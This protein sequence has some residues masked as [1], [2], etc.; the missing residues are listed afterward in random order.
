MAQQLCATL[1]SAD[2]LSATL[3]LSALSH[4]LLSN[5]EQRTELLR[6]QLGTQQ[7]NTATNGPS[8]RDKERDANGAGAGADSNTPKTRSQALLELLAT[9]CAK[10]SL[11]LPPFS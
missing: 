4:A 7:P 10:V 1:F 8:A 6:V 11:S 2:A 5:V 9:A 3:A